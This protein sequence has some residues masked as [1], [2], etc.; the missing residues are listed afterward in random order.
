MVL[1]ALFYR[2][3]IWPGKNLKRSEFFL[4]KP[5]IL[6]TFAVPYVVRV[7]NAGQNFNS[8][9]KGAVSHTASFFL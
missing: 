7:T 1:L 8:K 4:G 2:I 9:S 3:G 6:V 5:K